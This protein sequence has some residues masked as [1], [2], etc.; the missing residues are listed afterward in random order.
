MAK[1]SDTGFLARQASYDLLVAKVEDGRSLSPSELTA[2]HRFE[3]EL[4]DLGMD[5]PDVF[6]TPDAVAEYSGYKV[7]TI[8]SAVKSGHLPR[9]ADGGFDRGDVDHWLAK[10][11]RLPVIQGVGGDDGD[12]SGRP[13]TASDEEKRYRSARAD[14]E[15]LLVAR[16]RRKLVEV[17]DVERQFTARAYEFR[18]SLLLLSRRCGHKIAAAAGIEAKVVNGILDSE[19]RELL[20]SLSRKVRLDVD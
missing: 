11:K 16:L 9:L 13:P 18:T 4:K 19:A 17:E 2:M 14:R 8:Y 15:E 10:K 3:T 1:P 7:R 6:G 12:V 5:L 20:A